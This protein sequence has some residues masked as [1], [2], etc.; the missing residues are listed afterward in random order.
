LFGDDLEGE[1]VERGGE[2]RVEE[3]EERRELW[4]FLEFLF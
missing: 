3:G 4:L 1:I 2:E